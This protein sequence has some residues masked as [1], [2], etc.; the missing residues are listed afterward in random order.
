MGDPFAIMR[1]NVPVRPVRKRGQGVRE[2]G[3]AQFGDLARQLAEHIGREFRP[4]VILGVA[5]GGV[6]LGGALASRLRAEFYSIRIERLAKGPIAEPLSAALAK[7]RVLVVDD[8][9]DSGATL[10]AARA[11]VRKTR[12]R[13]IRTA[14]LVARPGGR[15]PNFKALETDDLVVFGWDYQLGGGLPGAS[16][17]GETGV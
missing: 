17:P 7:K 1:L 2:I 11:A 4:D 8:V 10:A 16:D 3:W 12:A 13:E 14:T 9:T 5:N 15:Q 6:F